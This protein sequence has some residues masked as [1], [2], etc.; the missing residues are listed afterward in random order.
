MTNKPRI[1]NN[2]DYSL[3]RC[4]N[5]PLIGHT[6]CNWRG[7]NIELRESP[8]DDEH[9]IS[10]GK[11][12][13]GSMVVICEDKKEDWPRALEAIADGQVYTSP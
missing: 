10:I 8:K 6:I 1:H 11:S 12:F 3:E 5:F 13:D 4:F 7:R 2:T 9:I